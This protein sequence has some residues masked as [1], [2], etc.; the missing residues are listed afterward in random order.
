[1]L[2]FILLPSAVALAFN[3]A[4]P[5]S[6]FKSIMVYSSVCGSMGCFFISLKEE[7]AVQA[8]QDKGEIGSEIRYRY[9]QLA[10]YDEL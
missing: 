9:S 8:R 4:N 6:I 1:M 3:L 7:L 2:S 10:A 5:F